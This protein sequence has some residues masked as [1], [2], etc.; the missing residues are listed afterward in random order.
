M[1]REQRERGYPLVRGLRGRDP[2]VRGLP[3]RGYPLVRGL[4]EWGYTLLRGLRGR[5]YPLVRGQRERGYPLVLLQ[6]LQRSR[7]PPSATPPCWRL[8]ACTLLRRRPRRPAR[9]RP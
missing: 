2:L 4:R 8:S 6:P 9:R 3:E 1:M 7:G 5:G